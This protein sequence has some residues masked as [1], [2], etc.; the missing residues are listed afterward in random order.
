MVIAIKSYFLLLFSRVV[1]IFVKFFC[2]IYLPAKQEDDEVVLQIMYLLQQLL[3]NSGIRT[4][5]IS[6]YPEAVHYLVDLMHDANSEISK[7]CDSTLDVVAVS[8]FDNAFLV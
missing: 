4:E 7:L 5:V 2:N 8:A 3:A 6:R 1:S